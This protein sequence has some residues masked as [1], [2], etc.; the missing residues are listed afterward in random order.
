MSLNTQKFEAT[1]FEYCSIYTDRAYKLI[2]DGETAI[3]LDMLAH[4]SDV[5]SLLI[6]SRNSQGL[7]SINEFARF[8]KDLP[9]LEKEQVYN[10]FQEN[11]FG[12]YI[13]ER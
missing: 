11:G 13:P 3:G 2:E 9:E 12:Q 4:L 10:H 5:L 8:V 7:I 6:D 1:M